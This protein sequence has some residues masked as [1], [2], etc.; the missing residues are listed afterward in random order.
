MAAAD[1]KQVAGTVSAFSLPTLL[2]SP[3]GPSA[4]HTDGMPSRGTGW[5]SHE[6]RPVISEAFSSNVSSATSITGYGS[7]AK[8]LAAQNDSSAATTTVNLWAM[9]PPMPA[10]PCPS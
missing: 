5:V 3:T 1:G 4:I 10:R 7:C 2:R 8:A 9:I 6:L